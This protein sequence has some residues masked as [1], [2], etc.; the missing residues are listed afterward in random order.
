MFEQQVQ[1]LEEW[2]DTTY[3]HPELREWLPTYLR[4]KGKSF[5]G[6]PG[7]TR[8]MRSIAEEQDAIGW[9]N[10]VEGRVTKRIRDMQT[11]YMCNRNVTYTVDHWMKDFIRKLMGL[12]HEMW[13]G[14]NLMKHHKTQGMVAIRT[15]E[16]LLEEADK[17]SHHNFQY[18]ED[19]YRWMLDL[20]T[21]AYAEMGCTKTQYMIFEMEAAKAQDDLVAKRTGGKITEWEEYIKMGGDGVPVDNIVEGGGSL[22]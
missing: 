20:E 1:V 10:F 7:L 12:S 15:K 4:G 21:E 17:L 3:T 9:T 5:Q 2:M 16:E 22:R 14:R 6:L 18:I 13:M 19:K 11:M 8:K